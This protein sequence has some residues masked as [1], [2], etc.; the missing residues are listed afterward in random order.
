MGLLV[1][2]VILKLLLTPDIMYPLIKGTV[3]SKRVS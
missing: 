3:H 2:L 1:N